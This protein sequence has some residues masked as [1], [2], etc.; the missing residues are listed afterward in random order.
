MTILYSVAGGLAMA[1]TAMV[2]TI[3]F[4]RGDYVSS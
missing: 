3:K 1:T 4:K 2:E